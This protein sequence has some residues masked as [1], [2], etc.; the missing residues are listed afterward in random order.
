MDQ[1]DRTISALATLN[2]VLGGG[3]LRSCSFGR[4]I[5][6]CKSSV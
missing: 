4:N 6:H 5:E 1:H 2:D 3:E